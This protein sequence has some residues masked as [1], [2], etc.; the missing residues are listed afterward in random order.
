[1]SEARRAVRA[2]VSQP[3]QYHTALW[4]EKPGETRLTCLRRRRRSSLLVLSLGFFPRQAQVA[5]GDRFSRR[6]GRRCRSTL[7]AFVRAKGTCQPYQ[8]SGLTMSNRPLPRHRHCIGPGRR[9]SR[10]HRKSWRHGG[11][12][13]PRQ[14]VAG[15][16]VRTPVDTDGAAAVTGHGGLPCSG[17]LGH[18]ARRRRPITGDLV[19]AQR[20]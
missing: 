14:V 18:G 17:P 3:A 5:R 19:H 10:G 1:M 8:P 15:A 7:M 20:D 12:E 13:H 4:K 9:A 11:Q 16:L 6:P 2:G